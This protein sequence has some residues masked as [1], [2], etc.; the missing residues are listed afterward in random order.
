MI[1]FAVGVLLLV[2]LGYRLL[3]LMGRV[4]SRSRKSAYNMLVGGSILTVIGALALILSHSDASDVLFGIGT[5]LF[6]ASIAAE[7]K[8][9]G[10]RVNT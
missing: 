1:T 6:G 7:G 3:V 5:M 8:Q 10:S 9:R 4:G 2:G